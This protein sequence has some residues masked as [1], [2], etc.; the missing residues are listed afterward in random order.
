MVQG[1]SLMARRVREADREA[2][3]AQWGPVLGLPWLLVVV[4]GCGGILM[5]VQA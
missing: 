1:E 2:A 5:W 3:W 4:V